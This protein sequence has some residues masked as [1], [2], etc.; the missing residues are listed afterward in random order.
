MRASIQRMGS[1]THWV[2]EPDVVVYQAAR[3]E[4]QADLDSLLLNSQMIEM[5]LG[6]PQQSIP[7]RLFSPISLVDELAKIF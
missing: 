5:D 2:P 1:V 6:T 4:Q 3:E 7:D